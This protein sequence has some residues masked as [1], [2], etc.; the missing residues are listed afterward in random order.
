MRFTEEL[1]RETTKLSSKGQ[2]IIR[3]A[4]REARG[5]AAGTALEIEERED[6]LLLRRVRNFPATTVADV[7]GCLKWRGA[8]KSLE[9]M[10]AAITSEAK[11]RA[12]R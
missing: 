5:W 12:K 4:L 6:G 11:Q 3:K 9:D 2:V 8:P 1:V 7:A 10:D